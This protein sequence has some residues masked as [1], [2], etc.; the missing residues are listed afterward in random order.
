[1]VYG[2][3]QYFSRDEASRILRNLHDRLLSV[4]KVFVG[5]LPDKSKIGQFYRDHTP[6]AAELNDHAARL[7]VWYEPE[8]FRT[9]AEIFGLARYLFSHAAR[10]HAAHYR[11]D[12]TLERGA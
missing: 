9:L 2:A 6:T 4:T 3:F 5:N 10:F 11:F 8:E 12:V 7:G 1:M